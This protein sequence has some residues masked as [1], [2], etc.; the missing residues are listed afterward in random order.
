[1]SGNLWNSFLGSSVWESR[2]KYMRSPISNVTW[3]SEAREYADIT[4][5][6]DLVTEWDLITKFNLFTKFQIV[7]EHLK[8]V[9]HPNR[10]RVLLRTL[11]F[12]PFWIRIKLSSNGETVP[13]EETYSSGHLGPVTFGTWINYVLMVKPVYPKFVV[14]QYW[15]SNLPLYY[16]SYF[17]HYPCVTVGGQVV[18]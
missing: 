12:V 17:H 1:M 9:W 11:G 5:T 18:P 2:I 3:H 16:Y 10:G 13:T 15:I 8:R 14:L 6:Y 7:I 4:L